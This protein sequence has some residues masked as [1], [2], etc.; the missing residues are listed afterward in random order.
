MFHSARL[1]LTFFYLA[2]LFLFSLTITSTVRELAQRE[3]NHADQVQRGTV[4]LLE[5][6]LLDVP[7]TIQTKN[8]NF[9]AIQRK[10]S[11]LINQHL[12]QYLFFIN[13]GALVFGGIVSYWYAGRALKPIAE[14]HEAQRRFASD[15][16]HELRTPLTN[17]QVE[18]E[19]FLRQKTFTEEEARELIAS[20]IEEVQRLGKL[21]NNLLLLTQYGRDSIELGR[22]SAER[23]VDKVLAL[24]EKNITAHGV[25]VDTMVAPAQILGNLESLERLLSIIIDNALKYGPEKGT[26]HIVGRKSAGRYALSI[27]DEGPGI[28]PKDMPHIF[29]RLYRGDKARSN[30]LGGYGLGLALAK[31]IAEANRAVIKASNVKKGAIFTI[32][33]A[34]S[35]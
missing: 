16:S 9:D 8:N 2:I 4:H 29:E 3:Y 18:N 10:E 20:N 22:V 33:F 26:I 17:I 31:N 30:K 5:H 14:A 15:A 19:V 6:Y 1:K 28:D 35:R 27:R 23:L 7:L 24:A 32:E 21:A 13:L 34:M 11:N 12:N 25:R